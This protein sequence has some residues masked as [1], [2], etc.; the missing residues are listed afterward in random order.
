MAFARRINKS[1]TSDSRAEWLLNVYTSYTKFG[2]TNQQMRHDFSAFRKNPLFK[3]K[4]ITRISGSMQ[5]THI[6]WILI[7]SFVPECCPLKESDQSVNHEILF[8][9]PA[10]FV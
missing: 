10:Y 5:R 1:I 8:S 9:S 4:K 3:S 6:P 2:S 7:I